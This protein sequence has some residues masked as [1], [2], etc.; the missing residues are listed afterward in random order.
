MTHLRGWAPRGERLIAKVPQGRWKTTPFLAAQPND[1]IDA[2]CLFDGPIDGERFLAYVEQ[3]LVPSLKPGDVVVLN[4]LGSHKTRALRKAILISRRRHIRRR[5][6]RCARPRPLFRRGDAARRDRWQPRLRQ[7]G[8]AD[9][10]ADRR[11]DRRGDQGVERAAFRRNRR[12]SR[13]CHSRFRG[14]DIS[15]D[16]IKSRKPRTRLRALRSL[17]SPPAPPRAVRASPAD[18]RCDRRRPCQRIARS[19]SSSR[20]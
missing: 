10:H 11:R 1:R 20:V 7:T 3:S 17:P 4:N 9:Q 5:V 6:R 15:G 12:H 8:R 19:Q 2:L 13:L 18:A 14:N 16:F